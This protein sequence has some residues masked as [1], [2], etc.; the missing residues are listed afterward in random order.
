MSQAISSHNLLTPAQMMKE[1][2]Q[3]AL[4]KVVKRNS[5][6]FA[7]AIMAGVFIGLAFMFY[8]TVTTGNSEPSWGLNR[9]VGGLVFSMG[10]ILTVI[11]GGEL[12][13]SSVLSS[14]AWAN[15][16]TTLNKMLSYWGRV[17][18]GNFLGS[19]F[20]VVLVFSASLYQMD[21]GNWGL[22][23]LNIATHKLEHS[24]FEAFALGVL[25][26]ILVCL[27]VWL[28]FSSKNALTKAMMMILPV[29]MFVAS[30]FEH[31]VANMFMIPLG[32]FIKNFAPDSFWFGL[33]IPPEQFSHLTIYHFLTT[34][35][36]P[37]TFGNIVGGSL[38]V[39]LSN[40]AIY[41]NESS[42]LKSVPLTSTNLSLSLSTKNIMNAKLLIKEIM[43]TKPL[44]L[45][46]EMSVVNAI[47]ILLTEN[48]DAAVVCDEHGSLAGI[49]SVHDVM[50]DLWCEDYIPAREKTVAELMST[51]LITVSANDKVVDAVEFMCVDKAS[52]YPISPFGIATDFTMA[53][54]EE[55]AKA[56][57]V[58]QPRLL[59]VMDNGKLM[60]VINRSIV[61]ACLREIYG[62]KPRNQE[63]NDIKHS[64]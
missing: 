52:L 23:V 13:T 50:V 7:L 59:P 2:E 39:G 18:V 16:K 58:H 15:K 35:L 37:V 60:G 61:L 57:K 31:C 20:L 1:A 29:A 26:N 32:I 54:V 6:A 25:C 41:R 44:L 22:N 9:L 49:F 64:A 21:H 51:N 62:H 40:W 19:L 14:I 27:A 10:L 47:D 34:N 12:F 63:V 5:T 46:T 43:N 11:C 38:I 24:V 56:M 53:S 36:I 4:S 28:T 8:I 55:R 30:G 33:N 42:Q 3:F 48:S 45:T 17:Y